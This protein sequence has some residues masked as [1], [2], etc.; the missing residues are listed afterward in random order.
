MEWKEMLDT[1]EKHQYSGGP[2]WPSKHL[3]RRWGYDYIS[4]SLRACWGVG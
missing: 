1:F 2:L 3:R 4:Q